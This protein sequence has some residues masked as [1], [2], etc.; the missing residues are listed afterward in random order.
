MDTLVIVLIVAVG[1]GVYV[2]RSRLETKPRRD[3]EQA[4]RKAAAQLGFTYDRDLNPFGQSPPLDRRLQGLLEMFSQAF[5]GYPHFLRGVRAA[6]PCCVFDIWHGSTGGGRGKSEASSPYKQTVAAFHLESIDLP[7]FAV[8]PEGRIEKMNDA[9]F[10]FIRDKFG[11]RDLDFADHPLFSDRYALRGKIE[12]KTR[13]LFQS[14]LIPFWESLPVDERWAA[15]GAGHSLVV[16]RAAPWSAGRQREIP[17][18][19]IQ[20]FVNR[21]DTIAIAVRDAAQSSEQ[22]QQRR[23]T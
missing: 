18:D 2:L 12:E 17:A 19:Q 10:A 1:L 5:Y 15:A 20:S 16:Y 6:G 23:V 3:R 7:E 13:T 11:G 14:G 4:L 9:A 22:P 8:S 21:A